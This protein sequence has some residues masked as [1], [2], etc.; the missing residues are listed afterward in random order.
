MINDA[1]RKIAEEIKDSL[2][3]R[4]GARIMRVILFGSRARG[5]AGPD[6]DFDLLVIEAG[7]V[8]KRAEIL[9][10]REALIHVSY[11]VDIWVMSEEE[12]RE[13]KYVVGGLAYPAHR[14]GIVLYENA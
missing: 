7:P 11:P 14:H 8:S 13:T 2:L 1:D 9:R 5:T 10:L 6:S 3:A 4:N 12:Y